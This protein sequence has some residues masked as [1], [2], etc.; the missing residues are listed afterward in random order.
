L[1][2]A[3]VR[4]GPAPEHCDAGLAG[5]AHGARVPPAEPRG[6][7]HRLQGRGRECR[8]AR[9]RLR[10]L[11]IGAR[12]CSPVGVSAQEQSKENDDAPGNISAQAVTIVSLVII[13]VLEIIFIANVI[14]V[15]CGPLRRARARLPAADDHLRRFVVR[16]QFWVTYRNPWYEVLWQLVVWFALMVSGVVFLA[17][18]IKYFV[19]MVVQLIFKVRA[20]AMARW[21]TAEREP[22]RWCPPSRRWRR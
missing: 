17:F 13:L 4:R 3:A 2:R 18:P 15:C 1:T 10:P 11:L 6:G 16:L 7:G 14:D 5:G 21:R 22:V 9:A 8:R 12:A 19:M 20:C